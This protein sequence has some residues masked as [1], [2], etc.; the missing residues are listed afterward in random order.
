MIVLALLLA[1]A[2]AALA[3]TAPTCVTDKFEVGAEGSI[4][5]WTVYRSPWSAPLGDNIGV[6]PGQPYPA[7]VSVKASDEWILRGNNEHLLMEAGMGSRKVTVYASFDGDNGDTGWLEKTTGGDGD[8]RNC[9]PL[10]H[11]PVVANVLV[12]VT[13]A[14]T[15]HGWKGACLGGDL[16]P[17]GERILPDLTIPPTRI[18]V[19]ALVERVELGSLAEIKILAYKRLPA[20][21]TIRTGSFGHEWSVELGRG[22]PNGLGA[23]YL[24]GQYGAE[25]L[26]ALL[27]T[28]PDLTAGP[29]LVVVVMPAPYWCIVLPG[30]S[31]HR[32]VQFR[33]VTAC[34]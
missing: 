5:G 8:M 22:A 17:L 29:G 6:Y 9:H 2:G 27:F 24:R 33:E 25:N 1:L 3:D 30:G 4:P 20:I 34:E 26:H 15:G 11:A 13:V 18:S 32:R 7:V 28:P 31:I 23:W 19:F 12:C 14:D 16:T 10:E 21:P